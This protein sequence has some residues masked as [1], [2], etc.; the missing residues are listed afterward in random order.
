MV[1][2][3]LRFNPTAVANAKLMLTAITTMMMEL[4]WEAL[5]PR[6]AAKAV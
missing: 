2:T 1:L 4:K 5:L 3:A 6:R